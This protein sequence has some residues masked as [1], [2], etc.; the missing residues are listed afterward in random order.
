MPDSPE[1]KRAK[2]AERLRAWRKNNPEKSKA[3]LKRSAEKTRDAR[4]ARSRTPEALAKRKEYRNRPKVAARR[5]EYAKARREAGL[6]QKI[7]VEYKLKKYKKLL[8]YSVKRRAIKKDIPFDITEEDFEI[9]DVCPVLGIP[10]ETGIGAG[11]PLDNSPSIDRLIPELGYVRG[12]IFIISQRAN[13]IK[14]CGTIEE[15]RLIADW[16]EACL[17]KKA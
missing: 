6:T 11:R 15:H 1:I 16:M 3:I 9:P 4:L 7:S 17:H 12:N 13:M 14:N 10:L 8:L 2:A 5:R